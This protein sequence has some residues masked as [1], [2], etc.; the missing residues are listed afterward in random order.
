[1]PS[2]YLLELLSVLVNDS[3]LEEL[4]LDRKRSDSQDVR[5]VPHQAH[6]EVDVVHQEEHQHPDNE[7]LLVDQF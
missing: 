1:M 3:L 5:H 6:S 4:R 7:Y 2:F